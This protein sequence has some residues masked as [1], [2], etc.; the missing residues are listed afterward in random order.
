MR[1]GILKKPRMSN[2]SVS[3]REMEVLIRKVSNYQLK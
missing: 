2:T 1:K 3:I